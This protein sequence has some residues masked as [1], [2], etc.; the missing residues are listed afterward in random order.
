MS[1]NPIS[2]AIEIV[3]GQMDINAPSQHLDYREH[4]FAAWVMLF[5]IEGEAEFGFSKRRLLKAGDLLIIPPRTPHYY[6][7]LAEQRWVHYWIYFTPKDQWLEY[8][9]WP[10]GDDQM[11]L[12]SV[13]DQKEQQCL[14]DCFANILKI[15]NGRHLHR[16][17]LAMN[18]L[19][20]IQGMKH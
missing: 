6:C 5:T 7:H 2:L 9:K 15:V 12:I 8:L 17:K 16:I 3:A 18:G 1:N 20:E 19:E 14:E 11:M 10:T 4:G 13:A